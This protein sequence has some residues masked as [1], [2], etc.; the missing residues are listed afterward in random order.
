MTSL[1]RNELVMIYD[2][3]QEIERRISGVL[4]HEKT[5]SDKDEKGLGFRQRDVL[6]YVRG[7]D[8]G[9]PLVRLVLTFGKNVRDPIRTL[10]RRGLLSTEIRS[11]KT[12][13]C[14]T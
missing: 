14:S 1:Q 9:V 12:W 6:R 2:R 8:E 10:A 4:N 5:M 3:I 7:T 11:N 13:V